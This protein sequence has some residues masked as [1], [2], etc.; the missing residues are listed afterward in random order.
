MGKVLGL[1]G[2]FFICDDP[3]AINQWYA[4]HLGL[5]VAE[6]GTL[7]KWREADNPGQERTTVWA[8]FGKDTDYFAPS[9]K[10]FMI[11]YRV[12]QLE[13]LVEQLKRD[14]ITVMD[15]IAVYEQGKF[16]HILDPEGNKIELWEEI[17]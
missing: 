16:V 3:Q 2:I 4:R 12:E 9:P 13:A 11:N 7:F 1:G 15:E 5:P 6:Y 17:S 14:G 10:T 8:T